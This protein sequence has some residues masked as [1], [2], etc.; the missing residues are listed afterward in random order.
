MRQMNTAKGKSKT[1][2]RK[3]IKVFTFDF[4]QAC[5]KAFP[6]TTNVTVVTETHSEVAELQTR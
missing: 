3:G 5:F 4:S 1:K 6:L 2:S